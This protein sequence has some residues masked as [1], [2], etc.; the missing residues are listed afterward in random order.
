MFSNKEEFKKHYSDKMELMI[1]KSIAEASINDKYLTL[2]T[3]V[4]EIINKKCSKTND[5]Y[6]DKNEK[7]VFYLSLEFLLRKIT[8]I[9]I[10]YT[11][12]LRISVRMV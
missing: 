10:L 6:L 4:R 3:I 9:Y 12:I 1:G 2:A 8:W 7:Q 5:Y 11:S